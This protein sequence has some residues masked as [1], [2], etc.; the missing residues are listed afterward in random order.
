MRQTI[1]WQTFDQKLHENKEIGTV[2][3]GE[4]GGPSILP[5]IRQCSFI[6]TIIKSFPYVVRN[7]M[8]T[9]RRVKPRGTD[10]F[11]ASHASAR[12]HRRA[13]GDVCLGSGTGHQVSSITW[14]FNSIL[15]DNYFPQ[16]PQ[17]N[18][19]RSRRSDD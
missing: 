19:R 6:S 13:T 4:G 2:V 3:W 17:E 18:M 15:R 10:C 12:T 14:V 11:S 1:S 8:T 16:L 7:S 5:W 9:K